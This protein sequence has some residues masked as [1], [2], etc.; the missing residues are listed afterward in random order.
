MTI[1][2]AVHRVVRGHWLLLLTCLVLPVVGTVVVGNKA[3]ALYEAVARVQMGRDPAAS[4]VEADATSERV[5]GIAT[6]VS[7]VR[8]A[9]DDV[10]LQD[11]PATFAAEHVAVRRVGVS[12]VVEIAVTDTSPRRAAAIAS[13]ITK[14]VLQFS[15]LGDQQTVEEAR[16]QINQKLVDISRQRKALVAKLSRADP[17]SVLA[18]QAD[19]GALMASQTEF[20]RQL[21]ELDLTELSRAKAV[22]LDP[23]REPASPLPKDTTQKSVLAVFIGA[24]LG[25]GLAAARETLRPRLRGARAISYSLDV[26][27]LGHLRGQ[28]ATDDGVRV[29]AGVAAD[30]IALLG[31]RY[32]A[33][34]LFLVPV[35]ESEEPWAAEVARCFD[36]EPAEHAHRLPCSVLGAKWVDPGARPV[37]VALVPKNVP[38]RDLEPMSALLEGL[39]W[40]LLGVVTYHR[41]RRPFWRR[42]PSGPRRHTGT[43]RHAAGAPPVEVS[44]KEPA[45]GHGAEVGARTASAEAGGLEVTAPDGTGLDHPAAPQ[46]SE[47][48]GLVQEVFH[49]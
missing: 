25:L 23:V 45:A 28:D 42:R 8:S 32:E 24:L 20:E 1:D 36:P 40:P 11:D 39:G 17:G 33:Q 6:S 10:D 16:A 29:A 47:G 44:E 13:S 18:I 37:A 12:S 26:P 30:R 35:R 19:L 34:R 21:S 48:R 46:S 4:N 43:A 49:R 14:S 2:E 41:T 15:N 27:H 9:L 38:E 5:L 31:Q 3:P 22:L 7:V